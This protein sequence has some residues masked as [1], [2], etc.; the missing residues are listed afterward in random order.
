MN[1]ENIEYIVKNTGLTREHVIRAAIF[2]MRRMVEDS[3]NY[4]VVIDQATLDAYEAY[5]KHREEERKHGII[6]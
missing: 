5:M 2:M 6:N 3:I 4:P 1:K